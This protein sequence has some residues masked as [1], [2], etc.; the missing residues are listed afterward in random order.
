LASGCRVVEKPPDELDGTEGGGVLAARAKD[1]GVVVD[2]D[3][4]RIS[5]GDAVGVAAEVAVDLLG[6]AERALGVDDPA[7]VV[8]PRGR[9]ARGAV[10][11]LVGEEAA[12]AQAFEA[13]EELPRNSAPRTWTGSKKSGR[14][15]T[16]ILPSGARPPPVTMQWA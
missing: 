16:Q 12:G 11:E 4:A 10:V 9:A 2:A 5:D 14:A 7:G 15:A 1:D 8:T 3:E 13:G 6:T